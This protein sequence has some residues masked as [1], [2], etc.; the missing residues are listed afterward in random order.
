MTRTCLY[1]FP[2]CQRNVCSLA[3]PRPI[4]LPLSEPSRTHVVRSVVHYTLA[5]KIQP[6]SPTMFDDGSYDSTLS[7]VQFIK[8]GF[9]RS[10]AM[11]T[12]DAA[13]SGIQLMYARF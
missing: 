4:K 10:Y 1:V 11:A 12:E 7:D 9:S 8:A 5:V 6:I 13:E 2:S 3:R